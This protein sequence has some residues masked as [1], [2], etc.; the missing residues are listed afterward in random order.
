MPDP[1]KAVKWRTGVPLAIAVR[2]GRAE[3]DVPAAEPGGQTLVIVSALAR[4]AGPFAVRLEA[5]PATVARAP[6]LLRGHPRREVRLKPVAPGALPKVGHHRPAGERTFH[7]MVR[8]GDVAS[9]SNYLAV[10]G[11]LRAVGERVQVYVDAQDLTRVGPAVL[12][13]VVDTFDGRVFPIAAANFGYARDVDGDGRFTVLMSHWLTRLAGGRHAV[14][15]YVRGADFDATLASPFGNRC[16]M[17]YLSTA[18]EPG[19]HLRTVLAHE[20]THAVILCAKAFSGAVAGPF[21]SSMAARSHLEEEGWLDEALAHLVEDLHGFSRSNL[22]YRVS[23][24]LSQPVRYRLVVEDYYAADLFRSHGNRGGTYLFLRWCADR[25]GPGL[26]PA[27]IRSDRRGIENIET[28]TGV[29]FTEL[30]RQWSAALYLSGLDENDGSGEVYRSL[31]LRGRLE[32]WALAG[33]RP[34]EV[35]PG[36]APACWSATGTSPQFLVVESPANPPATTVV[37]SGPPEADLQVTAVPL[38]T[39]MGRLALGVEPVAGA[40]GPPRLHA[41]VRERHGVGVALTAMAWEPLVPAANPR[42]ARFRSGTLDPAGIARA[43]GTTA[44]APLGTLETEQIPLPDDLPGDVPL[45]VK[46][47]GTDAGGRRVA[48]WAEVPPIQADSEE[49][50]CS[51]SGA[52]EP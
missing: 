21:D 26:L 14:D 16:D 52:S 33:P 40:E 10:R 45:V 46:V 37:V 41:T 48:A 23:A 3:F 36:D 27:L 20:Y 51:R 9:A 47:V 44:L 2:Q 39:G 25:F 38:P 5:R 28:A 24:F 12:R 4:G 6:A 35:T 29:P 30:Y 43:F 11:Q 8:H 13:D 1:T 50:E 32:G 17:M 49:H 19:P 22:D 31:D 34:L 7:I 18:L 42:G 15:G